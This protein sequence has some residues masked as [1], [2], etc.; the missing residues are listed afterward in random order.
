MK[1]IKIEDVALRADVSPT[2]VSR[3]MN[4][5]G[6]ISEKT[7]KKVN[8]AMEELGYFPNEV[9]RSLFGNKTKTIGLLFPNTSNPFYGC[10]INE[11][12]KILAAKNYK[13]LICNT[14]ND[15]E[16][17]TQ[18]LKMLLGNQ[19]DGIIVGSRNRP[20]DIYQKANLAI[21]SLD[22]F[23]SKKVP[24]VR[25]DNYAGACLAI[26]YLIGK[27]CKKIV[28]INGN[29]EETN[30]SDLRM[31]G[32]ID[33]MEKHNRQVLVYHVDFDREMTYHNERLNEILDAHP[34]IDGAFATADTLAGLLKT[35]S[36]ERKQEIEIV[37]YDGTEIFLGLVGN[38]ST[39]RQ[40]VKE[41]AQVSVDVLLD[42]IA[43]IYT[44]DNKEYVLS[45]EFLEKRY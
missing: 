28:L 18:Y 41:M 2:T 8:D 5:R 21:V 36:V 4:N 43:G 15:I 33:T 45:V 34:D 30:G 42:A 17:E 38:I 29:T 40:P 20:S 10:M 31:N 3:V 1:K 44:E 27:K 6:P 12:E 13:T 32:Y 14:E 9:A 25:S 39:I 35:I 37:G 7:R 26:D 23:V 22:R 24:N 11:I 19:V 16:K